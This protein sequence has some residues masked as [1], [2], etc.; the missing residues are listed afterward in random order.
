MEAIKAH[1]AETKRCEPI[2]GGLGKGVVKTSS[3]IK[4]YEGNNAADRTLT[5]RTT[6]GKISVA[7]HPVLSIPWYDI[8][9]ASPEGHRK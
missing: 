8:R 9:P 3:D 4:K 5:N 7:A 2:G 6:A 1:W